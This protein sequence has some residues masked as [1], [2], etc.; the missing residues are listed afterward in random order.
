MRIEIPIRSVSH[1]LIAGMLW[2]LTCAVGHQAAAADDTPGGVPVSLQRMIEGRGAL[3]TGRVVIRL[4]AYVGLPPDAQRPR[5]VNA[6][7]RFAGDDCLSQHLGDDDGVIVRDSDGQPGMAT[8]SRMLRT[9]E[10]GKWVRVGGGETA[11]IEDE[12]AAVAPDARTIGARSLYAHAPLREAV[13]RPHD[14]RPAR[15]EESR[16]GDLYRVTE[17]RGDEQTTLW[18]DPQRGWSVVRAAVESGGR[19]FSETRVTLSQ[20][21]GVWFP[22]RVELYT[23]SF[24]GGQAPVEALDVVLAEF[25]RPDQPKRLTPSDIGVSE[26]EMVVVR[27]ATGQVLEHA[28]FREGAL[29]RGS[30]SRAVVES[31]VAP[32][33]STP[34]M[35]QWEQYTRAFIQRYRLDADQREQALRLL[36]QCQEQAAQHVTRVQAEIERTEQQIAAA[37]GADASDVAGEAQRR[38]EALMVPVE[39]IFTERLKPGLERIPTRA[40]RAAVEG[41]SQK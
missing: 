32:V 39:R 19:P 23:A 11:L 22:S 17:T 28:L 34:P 1:G 9:R 10:A 14:T 26:N 27:D 31:A 2:G 4:E 30:P 12:R 40:Q 8:S 36:R 18:I 7:L 21:D 3:A 20:A 38:L 33:A 13:L 5:V 6:E 24:R 15:Y 16:D 37:S 25:N 29:R 35:S 41:D